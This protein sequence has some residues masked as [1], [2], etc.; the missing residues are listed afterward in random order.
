MKNGYCPMLVVQM[1]T[2]ENGKQRS[3]CNY[4]SN[5]DCDDV[6]SNEQDMRFIYRESVK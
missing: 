2:M 3:P 5:H 6:I 4:S 1:K